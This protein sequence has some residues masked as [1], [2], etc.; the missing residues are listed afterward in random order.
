MGCV[1]IFSRLVAEADM[2]EVDLRRILITAA[3][4]FVTT[5]V[6]GGKL[7]LRHHT[8]VRRNTRTT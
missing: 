1:R 6:V 7:E 4:H 2:R 3:M 5:F 8:F